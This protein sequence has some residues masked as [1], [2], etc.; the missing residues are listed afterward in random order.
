MPEE[1]LI[2]EREISIG[3]PQ[4][5]ATA[6]ADKEAIVSIEETKPEI[7]T[8]PEWEEATKPGETNKTMD[9]GSGFAITGFVLSLLGLLVA[10]I[11][12]GVRAII[13]GTLGLKSDRSGLA[14]A[15]LIIGAI[16]VALGIAYIATL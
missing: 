5:N 14:I 15:A 8:T 1:L 2:S 9:S 3:Q 4:T 13:F 12:C 10:A 6:R 7:N 16:D 11:P